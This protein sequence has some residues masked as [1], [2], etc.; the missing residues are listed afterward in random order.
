VPR[1]VLWAVLFKTD[2][3]TMLSVCFRVPGLYCI[4]T[5]RK[6]GYLTKNTP[7]VRHAVPPNV[8]LD[9]VNFTCDIILKA[10]MKMKPNTSSGPDGFPP[11]I[12]KKLGSSLAL[13]LSLIFTSFM[14]VGQVPSD[15]KNAIITPIYKKGLASDPSNYRPISLTS[16]F[17]KLMERVIA[18]DMLTYLRHLGLI[19]RHQH[20]FIAK[21]STRGLQ[22]ICLSA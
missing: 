4:A 1:A 13:P 21:R 11:V 12:L 8:K 17:C 15:W 3:D 6:Y 9:S 14:S 16:I 18:L 22:Q 7:T 5:C 2:K 10:I 20:G 19:T